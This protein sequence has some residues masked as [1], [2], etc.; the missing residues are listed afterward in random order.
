MF[1]ISQ[2]GLKFDACTAVFLARLFSAVAQQIF[3]GRSDG[4]QIIGDRVG[5]QEPRNHVHVNFF[6]SV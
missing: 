3:T 5:G 6:N 4:T 2:Q 1:G